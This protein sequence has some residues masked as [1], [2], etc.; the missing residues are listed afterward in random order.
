[1]TSLVFE[2]VDWGGVLV[3]REQELVLRIRTSR[4]TKR[5]EA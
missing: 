1:M 5:C 3:D 2:L 4:L